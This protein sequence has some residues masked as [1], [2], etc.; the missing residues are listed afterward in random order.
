MFRSLY[1]KYIV[2]FVVIITISLTLL[3]AIV[4]SM[5][6][7]YSVQAK[8]D[9][10]G[11][12]AGSVAN[13]LEEKLE[14]DDDMRDF[15]YFVRHNSGDLASLL[16]VVRNTGGEDI[17]VLIANRRG[18]IILASVSEKDNVYAKGNISPTVMNE[19]NNGLELSR[20]DSLEGVFDTPHI[21][22]AVPIYMRNSYVC[23]MVFVCSAE[24]SLNE[25]MEVLIKTVVLCSL[26][27]ML[28]ALIAIYFISDRISAPLKEMRQAAKSFAAGDFEVRV[29]VVG[30]D[31]V[32]ELAIAFNNMASSLASLDEMRN[33]FMSSVSH[34]MRTPMTT[35]SGFID[36]ILDGAIPPEKREH[37]LRVIRDEVQRLSRLVSTLLD[38]SRIQAGDRKF[39]MKPF[40]ICEMARQII[41]SFEQKIEA[42]RLDVEFDADGDNILVNG[43]HDAIYQILYNICDN[44]VK[45]SREGGLFRLSIKNKDKKIAVSV[46]NEGEGI[47][48]ADQPYIFERF[49]KSDKSR[50]KDKTG[51][52]LGMFISKTIINAHNEDISLR[53]EPGEFCEFTFTLPIAKK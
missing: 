2:T 31:E 50:G 17:S 44:A 19:V 18:E 8:F 51:V 33:N 37:Y 39:V 53:S 24:S 36:C 10:V 29:P 4:G 26:W 48:Y 12:A 49:Y 7:N 6:G 34:D 41:I 27:V 28:A 20:L 16:E 52:G 47:P 15:E 43:D 1:V 22:N 35:I 14:R 11:T 23:G 40:D 21:I 45:F 46:Y 5:V 42:K 25:F 30:K 9:T 13:F 38:I 32:A 3:V